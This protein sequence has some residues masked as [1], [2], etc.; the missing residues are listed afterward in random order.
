MNSETYS[1]KPNPRDF[2]RHRKIL[3]STVTGTLVDF[4]QMRRE[5]TLLVV[6]TTNWV[7]DGRGPFKKATEV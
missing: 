6:L 5:L 4:D 3:S 1:E 2:V 7:D